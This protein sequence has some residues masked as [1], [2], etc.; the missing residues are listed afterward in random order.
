M[1][2][3]EI[4]YRK[5][6]E[7]TEWDKNPR[8]I[9]KDA[10]E[11]LKYQ[12]VMLGMYKPLIIDQG[13][14]ILGGNMR[15]KASNS[16][17]EDQKNIPSQPAA[18]MVEYYDKLRQMDLTKVPTVLRVCENDKERIEVA[19]SDNDRAGYYNETELAELVE[20]NGIDSELF[21]IDLTESKTI[22]EIINAEPSDLTD[23]KEVDPEKLLGDHLC[24]CPRC[25][26]QFDPKAKDENT[27]LE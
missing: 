5:L 27:D 11:R 3:I 22:D 13:D 6:S 16:L 19:L 25:G 8:S 21:S 2:Q 14:M 9:N 26:F 7:L 17:V 20:L 18:D 12:I 4:K 23:D 24:E 15:F 10:F 1:K